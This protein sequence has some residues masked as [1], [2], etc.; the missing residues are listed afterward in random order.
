VPS[1]FDNVATDPNQ[2]SVATLLPQQINGSGTVL[3]LTSGGVKPCPTGQEAAGVKDTLTAYG[4]A[5]EIVGSYLD[6]SQQIQVT[7][8]V[9]PFTDKADADGALSTLTRSGVVNNWGIWCP[10][11]PAVVGSQVCNESWQ[12]AS[13]EVGIGVCHRYLMRAFA[14]YVDLAYSS[15]PL[16]ALASAEQAAEGA[17]GTQNIPVAACS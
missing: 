16:P 6:S 1:D 11:N 2:V 14:L 10:T 17:I 12:N 7:V 3:N 9:I 8:W 13:G 15:T 4:C 5:S